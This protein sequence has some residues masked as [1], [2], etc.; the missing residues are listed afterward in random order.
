[1]RF[2]WRGKGTISDDPRH[3]LIIVQNLPI[4]VDRRVQLEFHELLERGYRVSLICPKGKG[5]P[6]R[7]QFD[8]ARILKYA[9][10]PEAN[11]LGGYLLEFSY[12]WIR[13]TIL[14]LAAW[15][16]GGRFH[17]IQAC[18]PP[19]T[20]WLLAWLWRIRG[21]SFVFDHHDLNP[22]L[23]RSRFG[24]P[25]SFLGRLQL[26][27]LLWLERMTFRTAHR[28]ISTND[29]Y[30]AV[31]LRRG[32]RDPDDVA[33]VRSCPDTARMRP[34][35]PTNPA[36]AGK[37]LLAYLGIMG[38]QD[39]V[40]HVLELMAELV[41]SRGRTD[42]MATLM[43]FGDCLEELKKQC[44]DLDLDNFVTFTGRVGKKEISEQL[45]RAHIGICP[46]LKTPLND[47]STMNKSLEYMAYAL[48]VVSFDLAETRVTGGD[49][50]MYVPSGNISAMADKVE[51]LIEDPNLRVRLSDLGRQ[52]VVELFDW[53]EQAEV[54]GDVFDS[55][56]GNC[57]PPRDDLE[58]PVAEADDIDEWGR[59]Y[60]PL[61]RV[62]EFRAFLRD[63]RRPGA[64]QGHCTL[65]VNA[66]DDLIDPSGVD[67]DAADRPQT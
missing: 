23:F 4:Q 7:E 27:G 29:S 11:G 60:V 19:D 44:T 46:D 34:L 65:V 24:E 20:Y 63:R 33:V 67:G 40:N 5:D 58:S 51:H 13:T 35:Y 12:S 9:P 10:A 41:H 66:D 25:T 47:V 59:A 37:T 62:E 54:Y 14:S 6:S 31:A 48:P 52:R 56:T 22:E 50:I 42:V 39:G 1:M 45:S 36:P 61:D 57:A 15:R 28:V 26:Q 53:S 38:P 64:S 55:L 49:A 16:E 18:N 30:R 2:K 32:R 17:V 43:G 21:V 8:G 3:V